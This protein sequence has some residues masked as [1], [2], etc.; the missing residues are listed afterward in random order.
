MIGL[1]FYN[2]LDEFLFGMRKRYK[3]VDLNVKD[4]RFLEFTTAMT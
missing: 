2:F 4:L 3:N 1:F